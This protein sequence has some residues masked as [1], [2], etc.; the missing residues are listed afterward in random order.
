MQ[1]RWCRRSRG[2]ERSAHASCS[3]LGIIQ[4]YFTSA[5]Y[6][7]CMFRMDNSTTSWCSQLSKQ[8]SEVVETHGVCQQSTNRG[9]E[10]SVRF[11]VTEDC[12]LYESILGCHTVK[13]IAGTC[14]NSRLLGQC[15]FTW[16]SGTRQCSDLYSKQRNHTS[17][18]HQSSSCGAD[19]FLLCLFKM[20][21]S[22][23][24]WCGQ[25]SKQANEVAET[26]RVSAE[27]EQGIRRSCQIFGH[28]GLCAL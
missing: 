2:N 9:S 12:V 5:S 14:W 15:Q 21:D 10:H 11:Q 1:V 19:G 16:H 6:Y 13:Q 17:S 4:E 18:S 24:S 26:M 23:T 8:A 7:V 22:T 25:L 27:Q 28:G 3:E 20:D